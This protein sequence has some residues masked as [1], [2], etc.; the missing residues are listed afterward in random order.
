M[1]LEFIKIHE[2]GKQDSEYVELKAIEACN[3]KYYIIT[4]TTYSS[5]TSI[6]NK[7][8]HMYW[9][10]SKEVEKGDYI[11]LRTGK[12]ENTSHA[13]KAGTT[14]HIFYWGLGSPVWNNTGDGGILFT[15][16]TW[17]AKKA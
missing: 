4:D 2:K 13:N 8:R 3:L 15:L 6:S 17:L 5:E 12:G 1:S 9:F 14:T 10:K 11:L 16:K 7:L